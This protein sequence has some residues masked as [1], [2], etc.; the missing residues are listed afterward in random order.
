MPM[1]EFDRFAQDYG[2]LLDRSI[3]LSGEDGW[4]FARHK[5]GIVADRLAKLC[6]ARKAVTILD[7]G[8]GTGMLT[9]TLGEVLP[10]AT[11]ISV[12]ASLECLAV[13][14]ERAKSPFQGVCALGQ[15][16][17]LASDSVDAAVCACVMHHLRGQDAE[18][19]LREVNRVLRGGGWLFV[20]EHNPF[21]PLTCHAVRNCEFD[22]GAVLLK[23]I[24][25]IAMCRRAGFTLVARDYTVFFPHALR[26]CRWAEP[27]LRWA[28]L[29]AQY[30]VLCQ[31]RTAVVPA[32]AGDP[33]DGHRR[34]SMGAV[35]GSR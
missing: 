21:N 22:R 31:K 25:A 17:P 28:P 4:Y 7:I 34:R 27:Y 26:L 30:L 16:L 18:A 23:P 33:E 19:M 12:D 11:C 3:A 1:A 32:A 5:A 35:G 13:A 20:F 24:Q 10:K 2:K 29:G 8:C 6:P 15:A 14:K 9:M